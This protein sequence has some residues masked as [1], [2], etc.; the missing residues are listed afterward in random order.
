MPLVRSPRDGYDGVSVGVRFVDGVA[1]TD[2]PAALA[3]FTRAGYDIEPPPPPV[4]DAP[5]DKAPKADWVAYVVALG[6]L[7]EAAAEKLTRDQL[8]ETYEP[9]D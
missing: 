9:K 6:K 7:D 1:N 8:A 5:G 2:D 4:P 3:Y